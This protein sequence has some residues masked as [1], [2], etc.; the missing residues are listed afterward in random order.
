MV[1]WNRIRGDDKL[2]HLC[3]RGGRRPCRPLVDCGQDIALRDGVAQA[4]HGSL[5]RCEW[6]Y[7][8]VKGGARVGADGYGSG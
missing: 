3:G 4:G 8:F 7:P 5:R 2:T 6:D 1:Q